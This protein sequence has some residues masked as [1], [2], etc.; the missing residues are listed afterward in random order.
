MNNKAARQTLMKNARHSLFITR[1]IDY[2]MYK[3][4][5]C[6]AKTMVETDHGIDLVFNHDGNKQIIY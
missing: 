3:V 2:N 5:N 1:W 4:Y 6:M